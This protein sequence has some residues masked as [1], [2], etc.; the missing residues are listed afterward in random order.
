MAI[1]E[2]LRLLHEYQSS[3]RAARLISHKLEAPSPGMPIWQFCQGNLAVTTSF[4]GIGTAP[5]THTNFITFYCLCLIPTGP[6]DVLVR[7][8]KIISP[9]EHFSLFVPYAERNLLATLSH[10]NSRAI[11]NLLSLSDG[12]PRGVIEFRLITEEPIVMKF[13][14]NLLAVI[15]RWHYGSWQQ[16]DFLILFIFDWTTGCQVADNPGH[17]RETP[18]QDI[19]S[20]VA[21]LHNALY[22]R[23]QWQEAN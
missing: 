4:T 22:Q 8:W 7:T 10:I 1:W 6:I 11:I 16:Q 15:V 23:Y 18:I 14:G 20:H 19:L 13:E 9:T 17:F 5:P 3:W 2:R 12:T 21:I